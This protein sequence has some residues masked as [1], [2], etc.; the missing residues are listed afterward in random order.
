VYI[1]EV[2]G[3]LVVFVICAFIGWY[4]NVWAEIGAIGSGMQ[5]GLISGG[6][7]VFLVISFVFLGFALY[8]QW[9]G[10]AIA[11][12]FLPLLGGLGSWAVLPFLGH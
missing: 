5:A 10:W 12:G 3:S 7:K 11:V 1:F 2:L 8:R 6:F 4:L 9:G